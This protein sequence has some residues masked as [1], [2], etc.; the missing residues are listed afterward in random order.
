MW[1]IKLPELRILTYGLLGSL[2]VCKGDVFTP[3]SLVL[4]LYMLVAKKR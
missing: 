4:E 1:T 2:W 3:I